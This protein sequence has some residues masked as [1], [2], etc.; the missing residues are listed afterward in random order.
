MNLTGTFES[1]K[2]YRSRKGNREHKRKVQ[3]YMYRI[4]NQDFGYKKG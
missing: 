1:K 3:I 4:S 2:F